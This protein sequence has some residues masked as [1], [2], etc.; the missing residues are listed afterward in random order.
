MFNRLFLFLLAILSVIWIGYLTYDLLNQ[1]DKLFPENVFDE[2]DGEILIINRTK[3]VHLE[4]IPFEINE[5][6]IEITQKLLSNIYPNERYFL[7]KNRGII[8]VEV[9]KFW[10]KESLEKYFKIK[11]IKVSNLS[12]NYFQISQDL[13]AKY[14]RN[15]LVI[16]TSKIPSNESQNIVWPLWDKKASASII[17]LNHPLKSTNIYYKKDGT[18]SYQT[19]FRKEIN[20][21]K[22]D[23]QAIFGGVIPAKMT[24]YH[25]FEREYA[26][27]QNSL[28]ETSPLFRWTETGYVIFDY[29]GY[30]CL[31]SDYIGGQ[32]P[33]LILNELRS[34]DD[35]TQLFSNRYTNIQLT[36]DFPSKDNPEFYAMYVG[37]KVVFCT[38]NE[39]CKEIVADFQLGRTVSLNEVMRNEI[40]SKLPKKV[41][42]RFYSS[43]LSFTKTAY[44][45]L[46]I[47]TK[48]VSKNN[49]KQKLK[50]ESNWSQ[51]LEGE[52]VQIIGNSDFNFVF[53]LSNELVC[54]QNRKQLWKLNFEGKLIGKPQII[55]L[56]NNG[57]SQLLFN[58]NSHIYLLNSEG[59]SVNDFPVKLETQASNSVSYYR[60]KGVGNFIIVDTKNE[61][62][63]YDNKGRELMSLKL[64]LTNCKIPVDVFRNGNILTALV[65]G[66]NTSEM[67]DIEGKKTLQK[68]LVFP[69][70][71]IMIKTPNGPLFFNFE[72]EQ[73]VQR[74]VTGLKTNLTQ[75]NQPSML[76]VC[77]GETFKYI[78][79]KSGNKIIIMNEK[80]I[81]MFQVEVPFHEIVDYDVL[82]LK[83][84]RTFIAL[85]DGLKNDVYLLDSS[86]KSI[87][88][89]TYEGKHVVCLTENPSNEIIIST[90]GKGFVVQY[91]EKP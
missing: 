66:E 72:G 23:D 51:T 30:K 82:T 62:I 7:S 57:K 9:P 49:V 83:N 10:D 4:E 80:G 40:Y 86:G 12:N 38:N 81:K 73:L 91:F 60:W 58:T 3:E 32:D 90:A 37:D 8:L 84:G 71:R 26:L 88:N 14:H 22:I 36:T 87:Q 39:I 19:K 6:L 33:F 76:K 29:K 67:I 45:N 69:A 77:E 41:S 11:E 61:L 5:K 18:I 25:F 52:I 64:T 13:Y 63:H 78:T 54:I 2:T 35:T 85:V 16:S 74:D 65:T 44:K 43:E 59:N 53:T 1:K 75:H 46:D 42:E 27:N 34:S 47:Q 55:D 50:K 56:F 17:Q 21:S 48:I 70:K 20:G 31:V 89:K 24:T 15:Y 28:V 79:F 68:N